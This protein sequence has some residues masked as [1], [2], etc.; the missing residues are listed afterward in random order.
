MGGNHSKTTT[1]QIQ[2]ATMDAVVN[3]ASSS[4]QSALSKQIAN[5][6]CEKADQL[7]AQCIGDSQKLCKEQKTWT[8][9]DCSDYTVQVCG[10][11]A[12]GV[13]DKGVI[14]QG[15]AISLKQYTD[16]ITDLSQAMN[17]ALQSAISQQ[18]KAQG[19]IIPWNSTSSESDVTNEM[20]TYSK[21]VASVMMKVYNSGTGIQKINIEDA[22]IDGVVSQDNYMKV[23]QSSMN[24][25]SA[26]QQQQAQL[27]DKISSIAESKGSPLLRNILIILGVVFGLIIVGAVAYKIYSSHHKSDSDNSLDGSLAAAVPLML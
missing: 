7:K 6:N 12:C 27:A 13:G 16:N 22:E 10:V 25:N 17:A 23:F 5:I 9:N 26:L 20:S 8:Q 11:L 24:S 19:S 2:N 15:Q 4:T 1:T 14:K 21:S 3:V 18:A